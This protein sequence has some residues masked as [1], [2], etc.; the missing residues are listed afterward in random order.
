MRNID[1]E[2]ILDRVEEALECVNDFYDDRTPSRIYPELRRW[3]G[4]INVLHRQLLDIK[5]I[6]AP[7]K[8][9]DVS[10]KDKE[11]LF[12]IEGNEELFNRWRDI[13]SMKL[14]AYKHIVQNDTILPKSD[15]DE[16]YKCVTRTLTEEA[17]NVSSNEVNEVRRLINDTVQ[18]IKSLN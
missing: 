3:V 16:W 8:K 17:H 1:Q 14:A 12:T 11:K 2:Q 5:S 6:V 7:E 13:S 9:D 18:Y 10:L 15:L 4:Q